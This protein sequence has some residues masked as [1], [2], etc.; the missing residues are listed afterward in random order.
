VDVVNMGWV[1]GWREEGM[2]GLQERRRGSQ[3]AREIVCKI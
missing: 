2:A 1:Q 3:G